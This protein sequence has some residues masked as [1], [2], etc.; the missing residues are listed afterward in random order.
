MLYSVFRTVRHMKRL[1]PTP[2]CS[3]GTHP[4]ILPLACTPHGGWHT[5]RGWPW[6]RRQRLLDQLAQFFQPLLNIHGML[7]SRT[8]AQHEWHG[9][10]S[11][12]AHP[13]QNT[14]GIL[15]YF[16]PPLM[17]QSA[18]LTRAYPILP[19]PTT[20][21]IMKTFTCPKQPTS[22]GA[23]HGD[24]QHLTI[25]ALTRPFTHALHARKLCLLNNR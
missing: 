15:D 12:V 11:I 10:P 3:M 8:K 9:L 5:H 24:A 13:S 4:H 20:H 16:R 18:I 1:S 19:H 7:L 22:N 25:S 23:S 14:M 21:S 2:I 17:R 6:G